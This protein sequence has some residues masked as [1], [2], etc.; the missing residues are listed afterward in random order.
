MSDNLRLNQNLAVS[1]IPCVMHLVLL[2]T[3]LC[4]CVAGES[5][6]LLMVGILFLSVLINVNENINEVVDNNDPLYC[7]MHCYC[8]YPGIVMACYY[9]NSL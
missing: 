3:M 5:A 4:A 8:G 7:S 6:T 2:C 1:F 9:S